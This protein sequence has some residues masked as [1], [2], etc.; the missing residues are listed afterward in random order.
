MSNPG[1]TEDEVERL[2]AEVAA[3]RGELAAAGE[4]PATRRHARWRT[5]VGAL[6][7]V[8][9]VCTAPLAVVA[10][11][12][13]DEVR[14]TDLYVATVAPLAHDPAVQAAVSQRITDEIT[15]RLDVRSVT[16][17]VVDGLVDRGVS[18][19]VGAALDALSTPLANGVESFIARQVRA[20]VRSPQF[21]D[22]WEQANREAHVQ[23][24]ALLTGEGHGAVGVS[25][26]TVSV[27]LATVIDAVKARLVERG[28]TLVERL[29][30]V[31]AQFT[32]IQSADIVRAQ[33]AFR[34]LDALATALPIIGV[35]LLAG[36]IYLA[37]SRRR[38]LIGAALGVAVS[39]LLLG[40][41]LNVGRELYLRAV[42][43]EVVP[44]AAAAAVFDQLVSFIRLSLR[45]LLVVSLII[46]AIA[47]LTGPAGASVRATTRQLLDR[48]RERRDRAGYT[49][50]ELGA[51]LARLCCSSWRSS[52]DPRPRP[53]PSP[54]TGSRPR[55]SPLAQISAPRPLPIVATPSTSIST[56]IT[57]ALLSVSHTLSSSSGCCIRERA[58]R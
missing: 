7:I 1:N 5:A 38:A 51:T 20:L 11:W 6:L 9:A 15:T 31:Q 2:R 36:G 28:F 53:R 3:L 32:I 25:G 37:R 18:P 14:D 34:L 47:W 26:N 45:S 58:T 39:M 50:G 17:S 27:N 10:R 12:A 13:R 49:T 8:I 33:R 48:I 41:F 57:V 4:E 30:T 42:P 24:V 22:A 52:P 40:L 43:T 35:V 56:A 16:D 19:T 44:P 55:R 46:A 29:P 21:A 23:L 54:P